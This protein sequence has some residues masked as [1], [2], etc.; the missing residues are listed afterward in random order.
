MKAI[1]H[2]KIQVASYIRN[3]FWLRPKM[4]RG[5]NWMCVLREGKLMVIRPGS[6]AMADKVIMHCFLESGRVPSMFSTYIAVRKNWDVLVKA[7]MEVSANF[8]VAISSVAKNNINEYAKRSSR[9]VSY[10]L[11]FAKE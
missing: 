4:F 3:L 7:G 11:L 6:K 2:K 5:V 10:I 8:D 1:K 9:L